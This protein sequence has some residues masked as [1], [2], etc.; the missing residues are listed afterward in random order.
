MG[1]FVIKCSHT[2]VLPSKT[3]A[4]TPTD[5]QV[6]IKCSAPGLVWLELKDLSTVAPR[7][8]LSPWHLGAKCFQCCLSYPRVWYAMN[9]IFLAHRQCPFYEPLVK[10][11]KR[12]HYFLLFFFFFLLP[13][14][15]K[16]SSHETSLCKCSFSFTDFKIRPY[17]LPTLL[18]PVLVAWFFF[19]SQSSCHRLLANPFLSP[20]DEMPFL[21]C[22]ATL[23]IKAVSFS[24]PEELLIPH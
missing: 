19:T 20:K 1:I 24:V 7:L 3:S 16:H 2:I 6:K 13:H 22:C 23:N 12:K 14:C 9:F 10:T 18:W 11:A 8:F 4:C 15:F 5:W 21:G 17:G